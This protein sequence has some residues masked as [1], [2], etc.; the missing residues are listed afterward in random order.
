MRQGVTIT[1]PA[2]FEYRQV[3]TMSS[4]CSTEGSSTI[5]WT[6]SLLSSLVGRLESLGTH[7]NLQGS[8]IEQ[9]FSSLVGGLF[10]AIEF[11][12]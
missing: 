6:N 5:Q 3:S 11:E 8:G 12:L 10:N 7:L 1:Q 4:S 2:I 9:L